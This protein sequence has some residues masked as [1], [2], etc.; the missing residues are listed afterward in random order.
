MDDSTF[1]IVTACLTMLLAISEYL[2]FSKWEY[3]GMTHALTMSLLKRPD[4][5]RLPIIATVV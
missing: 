5:S 3:N 1:Q 4:D 2:P